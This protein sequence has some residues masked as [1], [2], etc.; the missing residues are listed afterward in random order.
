MK[1]VTEAYKESMASTLRNRSYALITFE[2]INSRVYTEGHYAYYE[3][4]TDFSELETLWYDYAYPGTVATLEHNRWALDGSNYVLPDEDT[5]VRDGVLWEDTSDLRGDF[6]HAPGISYNFTK[7]ADILGFTFKFD[8][9]TGEYPKTVQIKIKYEDPD[10]TETI[11]VSP[12]SPTVEVEVKKIAVKGFSI[13]FFS[14]GI[15]YRR[16]RLKTVYCGMVDVYGN[17]EIVSITQKHDIDPLSR[18]LP[19]ENLSFTILDYEQH[20]NPENDE[21]FYDMTNG[22]APVVAEFGYELDD[23]TIEWLKSDRYVL[24]GKPVIDNYQ[25]TFNAQGLIGSMSDVYYK[26][27]LGEKSFYNMALAVL[28]DANLRPTPTGNDPWDI[29]ESLQSLYTTAYLPVDTHMNCLQLIAHA[30]GCQLYSDDDNVIHIRPFSAAAEPTDFV[31]PMG[32]MYEGSP[33]V[34]KIDKLKQ[35]TVA[36]YTYVKSDSVSTLFSE[37]T[38]K[39]SL[40]VDFS[41]PADDVTITVTDGSVL[42]SAIYAQ[43]VDLTLTTG[44][45]TV[46]ITGKTI[47]QSS[48]ILTFNYAS[49]GETDVEENPLITSDAM[50]EAL[51]AHVADYLQYR[52]TYTVDYRGNPELETKDIIHL[53][54]PFSRKDDTTVPS[55]VLTDEIDFNGALSGHL[56]LKGLI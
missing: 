54:T 13:L 53:E 15:N 36:K 51:A 42:T 5:I 11:T 20:F 9:Q 55:L 43:A 30:C 22:A 47:S 31:L 3:T 10:A 12:T 28:Q 39:T 2:N 18:R 1:E 17:D 8:P 29:D 24:S 23:G 48:V 19:Q 33:V 21:G 38:N 45:K 25:V 40:H 4:V 52:N 49:E 44:T 35:I 34:D 32:D 7:P 14:M 41:S 16:A 27:Q 26:S 46:E 56:T 50:A 6:S 37:T